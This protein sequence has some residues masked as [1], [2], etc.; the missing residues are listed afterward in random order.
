MTIPPAVV[1]LLACPTCGAS[2]EFDSV[3]PS[4]LCR[5]GHCFDVARQGYVSLV[6]G[7]ALKFGGD[8]ADMLEQRSRFLDAGHFGPIAEAVADC[9]GQQARILDIGA[10]T[11][12]Y[13]H[14]VVEA[15]SIGIGMDVSKAA[16][17][18]IAR[19]GPSIGAIVADAWRTFP[20]RDGA[21]THVLSIFAPRN[22]AEIA[23]VLRADGTYILVTPTQRHLRELVE[24]LG[25]VGVDDNKP[26]RLGEAHA[27]RFEPIHTETIEF[28]ID[29]DS[30]DVAAVVGMGPS[31]FHRT[32]AQRAD[33]IARLP[34]QLTVTASVTVASYR[35][36]VADA[37]S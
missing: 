8:T 24:P 21:L 18:R 4:L 1:E 7:A 5:F 2:F 10:G 26:R 16:A 9:V 11:G 34:Q 36:V 17:R 15:G 29:L 33:A 28:G 6:S 30:S 13:L 32:P 22:A 27:G 37:V 35:I 25:M 3:Q 20:V 31:A 19:L 12:Y 23:R 14:Q